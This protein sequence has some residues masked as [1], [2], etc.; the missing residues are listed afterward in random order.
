MSTINDSSTLQQINA[1]WAGYH[2]RNLN[3][4]MRDLR[5]QAVDRA[6][7]LIEN[8]P[9]ISSYG[10]I[11]IADDGTFETTAHF[12]DGVNEIYDPE[13]H[14]IVDQTLRGDDKLAEIM[15]KIKACEYRE[16]KVPEPSGEPSPLRLLDENGHPVA[17]NSDEVL[18]R[19]QANASRFQRS[20]LDHEMIAFSTG[21]HALDRPASE[22]I[23][24]TVSSGGKQT[25]S[26]AGD[27]ATISKE[28]LA[29]YRSHAQ[30]TDEADSALTPTAQQAVAALQGEIGRSGVAFGSELALEVDGSGRL[31]L[32]DDSRRTLTENDRGRLT[33]LLD[34]ISQAA[35][36]PPQTGDSKT[37]KTFRD[38]YEMLSAKGDETPYILKIN[39]P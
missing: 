11:R 36:A 29:L 23:S 32:T 7:S 3:T 1:M 38:L 19:M 21:L 14:A 16:H 31:A 33:A 35:K 18:A 8:I 27:S 12:H 15:Q 34:R 39:H 6:E 20:F 9:M 2:T 10:G 17:S 28:A 26:P 37:V 25:T 22:R 4:E 24:T 30:N 13:L 5:R